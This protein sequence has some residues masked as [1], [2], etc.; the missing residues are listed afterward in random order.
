MAAH[1]H[2]PPASAELEEVAA[3]AE[4]SDSAVVGAHLRQVC[5][6]R[7]PW[8]RRRPP[9]LTRGSGRKS[10]E[11]S[12]TRGRLTWAFPSATAAPRE[13]RRSELEPLTMKPCGKQHSAG[14]HG[15]CAPDQRDLWHPSY[16]PLPFSLFFSLRSCGPL[17]RALEHCQKTCIYLSY[18][19][20]LPE[21]QQ[22]ILES[23]TK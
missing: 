5:Q 3:Q 14:L 1:H 18:R 16:W 4:E 8:T 17:T 11:R 22:R 9:P 7:A 23:F 6:E 2:H 10:P 15:P 12:D 13:R 21:F 20:Y 19:S